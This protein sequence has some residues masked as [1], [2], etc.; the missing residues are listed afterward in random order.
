[1]Q[2]YISYFKFYKYGNCALNS[3]CPYK[4]QK[5]PRSTSQPPKGNKGDKEKAKGKGDGKGKNKEMV[6][7]QP[8]RPH[9]P[10]RKST[11]ANFTSKETA[12]QERLANSSILHPVINIKKVRAIMQIF[13][14]LI[15]REM[16]QDR[17]QKRNQR[18]TAGARTV[19]AC[20]VYPT[21]VPGTPSTLAGNGGRLLG[22]VLGASG[23]ILGDTRP[24]P[25]DVNP[26]FEEESSVDERKRVQFYQ[27][28]AVCEKHENGKTS[29]YYSEWFRYFRNVG[30]APTGMLRDKYHK[31]KRW[32]S[33]CGKI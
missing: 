21:I 25:K 1:M 27:E 15:L 29:D 31:G 32:G 10:A 5:G 9:H 23:T 11:F 13:V 17:G 8:L 18:L 28:D 3:N 19:I 2:N 14:L 4:N 12:R 24:R 22:S 33:D 6:L 16:K 7:D 20:I 26:A 30:R